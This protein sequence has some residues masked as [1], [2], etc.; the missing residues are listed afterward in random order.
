MLIMN[1][2]MTPEHPLWDDFIEH[3][4]GPEGINT[5]VENDKLIF[6]FGHSYRLPLS[7]NILAQYPDVSLIRNLCK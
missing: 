6:D 5:R 4:A 1:P 7:R 3:L 2:L